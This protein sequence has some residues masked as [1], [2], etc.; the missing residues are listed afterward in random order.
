MKK[1]WFLFS[2]VFT[3][4]CF[5][6]G[7]SNLSSD[8]KQ[9]V[10]KKLMDREAQKTAVDLLGVNYDIKESRVIA[11]KEIKQWISKN[12]IDITK[13]P[14]TVQKAINDE[15]VLALLVP[16]FLPLETQKAVPKAYHG[17]AIFL[18]FITINDLGGWWVGG[19]RDCDVKCEKCTGCIGVGHACVC[20]MV[21]CK[22]CNNDECW[23]CLTC[24]S[25]PQ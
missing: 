23:P 25:N 14:A 6:Q 2:V 1:I 8:S 12:K 4:L 18:P 10:I 17:G 11:A 22:K 15:S 3:L 7:C 20:H 24:A 5:L 16:N 21:C 13:Y 19:N 9:D